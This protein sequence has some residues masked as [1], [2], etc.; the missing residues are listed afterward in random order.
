MENLTE[1]VPEECVKEVYRPSNKQALREHEIR[2]EFLDRGCI[3]RIG[4]K[5]IAFENTENAMDAL[6]AYT[7]NP[8]ELQQHWRKILD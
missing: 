4:C 6:V 5:S 8:W 2:I 7:K 1:P 3:I